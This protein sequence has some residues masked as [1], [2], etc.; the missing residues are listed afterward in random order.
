MSGNA[1][2]VNTRPD[3][4]RNLTFTDPFSQF[5][6]AVMMVTRIPGGIR[7]RCLT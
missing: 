3:F 5:S 4:D 6:T 1:S 7:N 2:I